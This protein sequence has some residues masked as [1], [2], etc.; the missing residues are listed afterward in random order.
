MREIR[1]D[2]KEIRSSL[3]TLTSVVYERMGLK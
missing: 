3:A 1:A 2:M